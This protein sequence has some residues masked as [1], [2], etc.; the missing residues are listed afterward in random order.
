MVLTFISVAWLTYFLPTLVC[1][2]TVVLW[3]VVVIVA[4]GFIT[5]K[6]NR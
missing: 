1:L 6:M 4:G 2:L 5:Q 3:V